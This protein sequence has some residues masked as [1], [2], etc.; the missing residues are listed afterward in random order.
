[1]FVCITIAKEGYDDYKRHR[2]DKLEN[3]NFA[4]VLG[5]ED[6]YTGEMKPD[7]F[8]RRWNP[9]LTKSK[10]EPRAVPAEEFEG[11]RWVPVRWSQLKVGDVIRL[12]RDEPL[13]AD[14]V[15]L[16]SEGENGL[17][18]IETMALDG[19]T[20][21]KSKQ[22][23][24]AIEDCNTIEGI[25]KCR[26][27]FVV[28]DPNP[29]LFNFDGRVSVNGKANPIT[30]T[31]VVYRGSILRNTSSAIGLV[32]N[33]G[34]ECKIRMNAN[35][36]PRAKRP[37]LEKVVNRIVVTLAT[38]VVVLSV[39]VSMGY[40]H[41][42]HTYEDHAWYLTSAQVPFYQIIIAFIIMF[43]NVV[44]LALYVSLEI[45]KVGQLLMLNSDV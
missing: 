2:L 23:S 21:L 35:R 15:L 18:Y 29:E 45:V 10:A 1:V 28:E 11:I 44:P 4:T 30:L 13:P 3:A 7:G 8:L 24:H 42:D 19:E 12:F 5:R 40:V 6:H 34:E 22:V 38:Y 26:A 20:N 36:H 9:F 16:H 31:E 32:I 25:S 27:E 37:A 39:G 41:W 43:N 14:I 33:T 17:A